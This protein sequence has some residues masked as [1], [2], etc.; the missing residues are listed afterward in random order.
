MTKSQAGIKFNN[1]EIFYPA[2]VSYFI[3]DSE[4]K[5]TSNGAVIDPNP[6]LDSI[7]TRYDDTYYLND[8][9]V[10]P[11]CQTVGHVYT[12]QITKKQGIS[13]GKA[14]AAILTGG[15]S[16][17]AT[18]LSQKEHMTEGHCENCKSTWHF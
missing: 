7:S 12:K 11:H 9:L 6:T 4:L 17:L 5:Q 13:G 15:T 18:G 10:C 3:R 14:T 8:K 16:I 2:P 1:G